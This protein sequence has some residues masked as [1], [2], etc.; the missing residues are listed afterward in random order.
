MKFVFACA[1]LVLCSISS[2]ES[3]PWGKYVQVNVHKTY[4]GPNLGDVLS[5]LVRMKAELKNSL[6]N[7]LMSS[8]SYS[9][10]YNH[11]YNPQPYT[12]T[13]SINYGHAKAIE[14]EVEVQTHP[15]IPKKVVKVVK[16]A[17]LVEHEKTFEFKA[18]ST[19]SASSSAGSSSGS[20]VHSSAGSDSNSDLVD[21]ADHQKDNN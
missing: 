14:K 10:S 13:V 18:H 8:K 19:F 12:K 6:W 5:S 7:S 21:I 3:K 16:V 9:Y 2:I 20:A 17:P 1:L 4:D 15:P 11:N